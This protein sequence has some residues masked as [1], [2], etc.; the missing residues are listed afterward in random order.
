METNLLPAPYREKIRYRR[1]MVV[2]IRGVGALILFGVTACVLANVFLRDMDTPVRDELHNVQS[3]INQLDASEAAAWKQIETVTHELG[4]AEDIAGQPKWSVLLAVLAAGLNEDVYLELVET[5]IVRD[6][7]TE[8][9]PPSIA[10]SGPYRVKISGVSLLQVDATK[11]AL[12]LEECRL[13]DSVR[14]VATT[15]RPDVSGSAVGFEIACEIG[16]IIE[17][18]TP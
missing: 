6:N 14:L 16:E 9:S 11:Y 3:V 8:V 13:F 4:V 7:P 18:A 2:W 1:R 5:S 15:P 12:F 17:E 10:A